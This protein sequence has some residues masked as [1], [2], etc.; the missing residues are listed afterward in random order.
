VA[1]ATPTTRLRS[2]SDAYRVQVALAAAAVVAAR[3]EANR[4][5]ER[6]AQTI[7]A[8][9][10][11]AAQEAAASVTAMLAEQGISSTQA[12]GVATTALAGYAST[13]APLAAAVDA[14]SDLGMLAAG[15]VAD[16]FRQTQMV[17]GF[18]RGQKG[19]VRM[20]N[21]PSCDR[22][23]IL[24]G[25]TYYGN[26]GVMFHQVGSDW[27][28]ES[29]GTP[30]GFQR[31][32]LCDC[33]MI[34]TSE[35]RAGDLTTDPRVYFD[36]LSPEEQ[37]ATF[38][39]A[40]AEAIRLGSDISQVVNARSGMRKAQVFG[41]DQWLTLEGITRRGAFGRI[42]EKRAAEG[43]HRLP[44]RLMPESILALAGDDPAHTLRLLK[45]YGYL[46]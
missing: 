15:V 1:T 8:Y 30:G 24:A 25:A 44:V 33:I 36:S 29:N 28:K 3:R 23:I 2:A 26:D 41:R 5:P 39:K 13:G 18:N 19:Y 17:A 6:I 16:T 10:A 35:D 7:A 4:T 31:H 40:A 11:L 38:G 27:V 37:D 32:P 20:L 45:L 46:V 21:P 34:P 42:N 22:C 14:T 12:A 9:Q 43:K